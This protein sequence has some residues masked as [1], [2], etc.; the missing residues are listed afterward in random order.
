LILALLGEL[1]IY[2]VR[3]LLFKVKSFF[4]TVWGQVLGNQV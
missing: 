1:L 4:W 2:F 3:T